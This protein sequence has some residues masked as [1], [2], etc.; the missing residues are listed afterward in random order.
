M[1]KDKKTV[2]GIIYLLRT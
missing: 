1:R 2:A